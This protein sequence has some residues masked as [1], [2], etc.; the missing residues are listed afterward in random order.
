MRGSA[1][2]RTGVAP[3]GALAGPWVRNELWRRARAV[4]SLD[5]PFS[6]T[7]SLVDAT[8][9]SNLVTFTRAS[10]GTF[11]GSDGLI[12]TAVT[13]L[14][15]RS[16]EF[17]TTWSPTRASITVDA[18]VAP[19]GT[20]TADK[21][22][23]DSTAANTHTL[24]QAFSFIGGITYTASVYVKAAERI[25][26]NLE[27]GGSGVFGT[28]TSATFSLLDGSVFSSSNSP[29][30]SAT[31]IGNG[32]WRFSVS[33]TATS[34][35][36]SNVIFYLA[37]DSGSRVYTGDGTSGIFLWGA[38]LEQSSTVGEYIPTT[39]TINSAPRFDHNPVTGES[40]GLLVEE[41]RTNS[42]RNNTMVGAVAGT[43]GTVPTNWVAGSA[44]V[45]ISREIIG[46][47]TENGITYIDLKYSGTTTGSGLF[48]IIPDD[49]VTASS[50]QA[51]TSSAYVKV[52]GGSTANLTLTHRIR[53]AVSGGGFLAATDQTLSPVS[54]DL[55]K[56]RYTLTLSSAP[57]TI[58]SLGQ[59]FIISFAASG[60]AIDVTLRIGLP[61]L[62]QG[63]F[64][65]S[66]IPTTT[67]TVT[68]SADVASISG[69]N[70]SSWFN[71]PLGSLF[72]EIHLP[73]T[74]TAAAW[75]V[76]EISGTNSYRLRNA[77]GQYNTDGNSGS[78]LL[79][80]TVT[81][82]I[83]RIGAAFSVG[84]NAISVNGAV[85]AAD[86]LSPDT[87][88]STTFSIGNRPGNDRAINGTIRRLT[89]WPQRLSNPTLQ[90]ITQ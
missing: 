50:G 70:F 5:L 60:L 69:S 41:A 1:V 21:L 66:V 30:T 42:I 44:N 8:T 29:V 76:W 33:K 26:F 2:F 54:G 87:T 23:E 36:G 56:N 43:P 77:S 65:T 53:Q 55:I 6:D 18:A 28:A 22:A 24:Q 25:Y 64:A 20:V 82:G 45:G 46:T 61:Q 27:L 19:N 67:A 34:S 75:R 79:A 17:Q 14:L 16:E 15:L 52:I 51:W 78:T 71:A 48:N 57:A 35:A 63:A 10:S 84:S 68:R 59:Y 80:G 38:Q 32:W 72:S 9:G 47:G 37:N 85:A 62:E 4:P 58:A 31:S 74:N 40:L 7:K 88:G 83:A 73:Q 86:A 49:G 89:Y 12:Q 90:S 3:G 81:T 39:S 13:N 11:V